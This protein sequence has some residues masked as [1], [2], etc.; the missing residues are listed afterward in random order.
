MTGSGS[1]GITQSYAKLSL[2]E[3]ILYTQE[4]SCVVVVPSGS[5]GG[6]TITPV[7]SLTLM[8][9]HGG[10]KGLRLRG[11]KKGLEG[12]WKG[13]GKGLE[14]AWSLHLVKGQR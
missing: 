14:K 1:G 12:A 4:P 11:G 5:G 2:M 3:D 9:E 10:N 6:I 7:I 13:P 8:Q